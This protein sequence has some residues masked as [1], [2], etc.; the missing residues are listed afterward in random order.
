M[1]RNRR[2]WSDIPAFYLPEIAIE[3]GDEVDLGETESRHARA[4]RMERGERAMI[5][6]GRGGR[7]FGLLAWSSKR[8][9]TL[10]VEESTFEEPVP[11]LYIGLAVGLLSDRSRWEFLYEKVVELG[12]NALFPLRSERAEGR[13]RRDRLERVGVAALKQSQRAWLPDVSD[14]VDLPELLRLG[15]EYDQIVIFH[16]KASDM[17]D[18]RVDIVSE[19]RI[20]LLVGPE[21]GFSEEEVE[22][23][24]EIGGV[25]A[26]LGPSRLLAETA[27][28][29]AVAGLRTGW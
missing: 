26:G 27:A 17:G 22:R 24:E 13:F 14:P 9:A 5:L 23:A 3:V 16:E 12:L 4:L 1:V 7:H 21:G 15:E 8:V 10:R 29:V 18:E 11:G 19:G 6:D 20:L 25:V 2:I 28:I